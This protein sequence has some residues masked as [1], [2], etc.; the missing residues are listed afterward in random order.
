MHCIALHLAC[1]LDERYRLA[2]EQIR[3]H[4]IAINHALPRNELTSQGHDQELR[5]MLQ[6]ILTCYLH[7]CIGGTALHG[8]CR[9][10]VW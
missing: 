1:H 4:M 5:L 8:E 9:R 10:H 3:A 6:D 7:A 2:S